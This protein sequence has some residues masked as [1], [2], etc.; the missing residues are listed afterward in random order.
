MYNFF[1]ATKIADEIY[2]WK[3]IFGG[4]LTNASISKLYRDLMCQHHFIQHNTHDIPNIPSLTQHGFEK[5]MTALIQA[6]PHQEYE[7]LARAVL[8]MPISNADDTRERFPKELSRRLFPTHEDIQQQQRVT[9][10]LSADPAI[11]LR[12]SNPMPPPPASQPPPNSQPAP[13]SQSFPIG[14]FA[15]R[16][17]NPYASSTFSSAFD[18]D[19][20][21]NPNNPPIE[22][23]RKPY[24]AR[25]GSGKV[26][27]DDRTNNAA[28]ADPPARQVRAN[29]AIPVQPPFS[30]Q[31]RATEIP[32]NRAHRMSMN[33]GPTPRFG[34]SPAVQNPYT[35]SEG[36]N[37]GDVPSQF[38]AS[39]IHEA[40][41]EPRRP[42]RR[43]TDDGYGASPRT[44]YDCP[45]PA[46]YDPRRAGGTDG[47]GS[48][49]PG[50]NYAP[51]TQQMPRH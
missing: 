44:V 22:R 32:A 29:S 41:E 19:E 42:T 38:Y 12:G 4:R 10:A 25:G 8:D 45:Q 15:E 9:A 21:R 28:R 48:F 34:T 51:P 24:T 26:Y 39:N 27:E 43:P 40:F 47:Y 30:Q 6:H 33:G 20:L 11:Q 50:N 7:R 49:T 36:T 14:A 31:S 46:S 37:V 1:E 5:F 18:D 17:R 3:A 35:R 13:T 23:E 2:P 16:Q